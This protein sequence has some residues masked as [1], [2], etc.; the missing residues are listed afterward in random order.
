MVESIIQDHVLVQIGSAHGPSSSRKHYY[1][2][3]AIQQQ[4]RAQSSPLILAVSFAPSTLTPLALPL[5][6]LI[7]LADV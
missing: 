7:R 4:V 2:H 5:N 6:Q 3:F 1:F